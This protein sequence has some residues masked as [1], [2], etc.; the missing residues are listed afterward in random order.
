MD[1]HASTGFSVSGRC[2]DLFFAR[3]LRSLPPPSAVASREA[4]WKCATV[5]HDYPRTDPIIS[6]EAIQGDGRSEGDNV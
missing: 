4:G 3:A 6:R 2:A 1:G 5:S